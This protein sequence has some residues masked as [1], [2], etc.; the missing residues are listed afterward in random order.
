M[1]VVFDGE[2]KFLKP[3]QRFG[4]V[5]VNFEKGK[6]GKF[7]AKDVPE[8]IARNMAMNPLYVIDSE[9]PIEVREFRVEPNPV[10]PQREFKPLPKREKKTPTT[11]QGK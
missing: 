11:L 9:K 4:D 3:V 8:R 10:A 1:N 7:V 6:D 5:T 2:E